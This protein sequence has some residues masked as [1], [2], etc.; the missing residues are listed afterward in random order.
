MVVPLV[1]AKA[2]YDHRKKLPKVE[3]PAEELVEEKE[4]KRPVSSKKKWANI[5][6]DKDRTLAI[7]EE[8]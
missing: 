5:E 8:D 2:K 3:L 7:L 1:A 4:N 6:E